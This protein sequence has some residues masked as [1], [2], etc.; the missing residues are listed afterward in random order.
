MM[1]SKCLMLFSGMDLRICK[2]F[3]FY[4]N[5]CMVNSLNICCIVFYSGMFLLGGPFS[6]LTWEIGV[7]LV[8]VSLVKVSSIGEVISK[9]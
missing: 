4:L 5:F 6:A 1:L 9:V 2:K 8:G 3:G 7:C